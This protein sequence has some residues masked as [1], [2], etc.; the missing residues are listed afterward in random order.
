MAVATTEVVSSTE[1]GPSTT[2]LS[3]ETTATTAIS[4]TTSSTPSDGDQPNEPDIPVIV[5][6]AVGSV[7]GVALLMVA[8]FI[9]IRLERKRA[10]SGETRGF[11]KSFPRLAVVWPKASSKQDP[12][13]QLSA[14]ASDTKSEAHCHGGLTQ[15]ALT[16][17]GWAGNTDIS[18]RQDVNTSYERHELDGSEDVV[19]ELDS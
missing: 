8:I 14:L 13:V 15:P 16:Q 17:T 19:R 2:T 10:A 7:V 1:T 4:P 3:Q 18:H 11:L 12:T 6:A 5:G 9:G